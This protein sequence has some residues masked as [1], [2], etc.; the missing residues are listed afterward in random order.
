MLLKL[1]ALL[2]CIK[3]SRCCTEMGQYAA[4]YVKQLLFVASLKINKQEPKK[5]G[6]EE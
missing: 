5:Q 4:F 3:V 6:M 2:A 1:I